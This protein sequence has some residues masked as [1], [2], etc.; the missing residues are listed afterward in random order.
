MSIFSKKSF[1]VG[2]ALVTIVL[3]LASAAFCQPLV[4]DTLWTK[5]YGDINSDEADG[6]VETADGDIIIAGTSYNVQNANYDV[7]LV[8]TT[9]EGDSVWSHLFGDMNHNGCSAL[10]LTTDGGFILA[11]YTMV[12]SINHDVLLIKTDGS[13]DMEWE[14][15]FG[16]DGWET[17]CAVQQTTD[18]GY[19][20]FGNTNSFGA[21]EVDM[22]LVKTDSQGNL[23]WQN[24]YHNAVCDNAFD[25]L[26]TSDGG[27]L[28]AGI[29][30]SS[31]GIERAYAVKTD[32]AGEMEWD[33]ELEGDYSAGFYA[34]CKSSDGGYLFSGRNHVLTLSTY[35]YIVKTDS[36]GNV[37][38]EQTLDDDTYRSVRA[39]VQTEDGGYQLGCHTYTEESGNDFCFFKID[40]F[41]RFLQSSV[42]N[43]DAQ[44]YT[45][46]MTIT[47][48][49][50]VVLCGKTTSFGVGS[51]DM[52]LVRSEGF[53]TTLTIHLPDTMTNAGEAI[54]IPVYTTNISPE[55][56]VLAY[57]MIIEYD[58]SFGCFDSA[59]IEGCITPD[60]YFPVWNFSQPGIVNGGYVNLMNLEVITGEGA[61][62]YLRFIPDGAIT[63]T[64]SLN[65]ESFLFNESRPNSVTYDGSI[66]IDGDPVGVEDPDEGSVPQSNALLFNY[67]NPFNPTTAISYQLQAASYVEL[68]IY[69]IKGREVAKLVNGWKVAGVYEVVFDGGEFSSGIYF[70]RLTVNGFGETQKMVLIR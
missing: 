6:V 58:P 18:E 10:D 69:D 5:T 38:W 64:M 29:T 51:Y 57:Q 11:G 9:S 52:F 22:Y 7:R 24:R 25:G 27:Y 43:C 68:T 40:A 63:G 13:G 50:D 19:V 30:N 44:D 49:K 56:S 33:L 39:L 23:E 28:L 20:I 15:A 4:M 35:I 42:L 21:V 8:K 66:I 16:G 70:A 53:P 2:F 45:S 65:F 37:Q 54:L 47:V 48:D 31:P 34:V 60:F 14:S 12:G 36:E 1:E 26:Q 17:A 3:L 67:P 55:D 61:L 46:D 41:G 32:S 59:M 62:C